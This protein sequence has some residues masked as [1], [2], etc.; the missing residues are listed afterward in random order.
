MTDA[1]F[2]SACGALSCADLA[3]RGIHIQPVTY[4]LQEELLKRL[5]H[6]TRKQLS[7][8]E[9]AMKN[10]DTPDDAKRRNLNARTLASLQASVE[11]LERLYDQQEQKRSMMM[12]T[13]NVDEARA[14]LERRLD[15]RLATFDAFP[16]PS[17]NES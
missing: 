7:Q 2:N 5:Y 4:E 8:L 16:C 9:V 13:I 14:A 3:A 12:V 6:E 15:E 10:G 1:L 11:R 17:G